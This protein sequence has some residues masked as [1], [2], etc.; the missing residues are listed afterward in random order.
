[1]SD[2]RFL[3]LLKVLLI[4]STTMAVI[5]LVFGLPA[6][7]RRDRSTNWPTA[8]GTVTTSALQTHLVKPNIPTSYRPFVCYSY[9][10][11]DVPRAATKI[12]FHDS[13]PTFSKDDGLAWLQR[14][15]PIGKKV[16]VFYNPGNPDM[17]VLVP[18]AKDLMEIA[19]SVSGATALCCLLSGVLTVALKVGCRAPLAAAMSYLPHIRTHQILL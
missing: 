19:L 6:A 14:N 5:A 18:G 12:D 2:R 1:M 17:A 11:D 15:Y 8:S 4:V 9:T 13:F 10:V 16:T 3:K 7:Y